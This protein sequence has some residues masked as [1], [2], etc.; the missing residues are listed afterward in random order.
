[1]T[2]LRRQSLTAYT[3]PLCETVVDCPQPQGSEVLVRVTRCGVC[4]SDL[5][6]QDGY[7]VLGG[8]KKLDVSSGRT[9]PFTLGH[10]IAGVVERA[11]PARRRR[12]ARARGRGVPLDRMRSMS[13]LRWRARRTCARRRAT[14]AFIATAGL[15]AMCWS[16]IRA[17]SSIMR[18]CP[19]RS[20]AR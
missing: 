16:R 9:L 18:R 2:P 7:F 14:S 19:R 6:M 1:M 20:P 4:H 12:G 5:H 10:E 8:D 17:I 13:G 3:A 11:G 15:Q